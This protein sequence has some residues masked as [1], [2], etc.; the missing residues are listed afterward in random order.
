MSRN[1][2]KRLLNSFD[3]N[4]QK[5]DL[6]SDDPLGILLRQAGLISSAQ[7]EIAL[8]QQSQ[9]H[10]GK[11]LGEILASQGWLKSQTA[12]F[13]VRELPK[14]QTQKSP[15]PIGQYFKLAGLLNDKQ[16]NQILQQQRQ[17]PLKFGEL[18]VNKGWLLRE[19]LNF[20]LEYLAGDRKVELEGDN[21]NNSL[22]W[23]DRKRQFETTCLQLLQLKRKNSFVVNLINQIFIWTGGE[24]FLTQKLCKIIAQSF[25]TAGQEAE[26]IE[27]LVQT[28]ILDDWQHN[29]AAEHLNE[30]ENQI[31]NNQ[32]CEPFRLLKL[33]QKILQQQKINEDEHRERSQL[34]KIGLIM[35]QQ[36]KLVVTNRIYRSVFN[37]SWIAQELANILKRS[38]QEA[39]ILV[40][41]K[42]LKSQKSVFI[43]PPVERKKQ[44][45]RNLLLIILITG[46]LITL[47]KFIARNLKINSL[48]QQ[49]NQL[50]NQKAYTKAIAEYDHLLNMDS[51]Y[52]QAWTNRGYALAGLQDYHKM[53][54]SCS[55]ATI[56]EPKAVYAWN[57]KGEALHNLQRYQEAVEAFDRAIDLNSFEPIFLMNKSES[58]L[59]LQQNDQSLATIARAIEIFEEI[60]ADGGQEK[61]A[62]EFAIALNY[63]GRAMLRKQDYEQAIAS[64][65]RALSHTPNYFPAQIGKGIALTQLE[66][67]PEAGEEFKEI[68]ENERLTP[69]QQA[70]TWFY[71]GQTLCK[72]SQYLAGTT[73]FATALKLQ[74]NYQAA[75]EA[76]DNCARYL[77]SNQ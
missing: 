9:K 26:Q 49:G 74:P 15:Q 72:S 16:I 33:Y 12:D 50:L 66:Q 10:K 61:I 45:V 2:D 7:L 27:S 3:P 21:L 54:Q 47:F 6:T 35:E 60:E 53:L 8:Q 1:S 67:Y 65:D 17:K 5:P 13:F 32:Q 20:F 42:P 55:T 70:E 23:E 46:I 4:S 34:L 52:Y 40:E 39:S 29:V 38:L 77:N 36:G 44:R 63:Q 51:N 62:K 11:K 28:H 69:R 22:D 71:L 58:L 68:L 59:T 31:L 43:A 25:I 73:A 19:T 41:N 37:L 64:Y 56:I 30:I 57:C 76:R 14:L 24:P 75:Q 48:F 18:A